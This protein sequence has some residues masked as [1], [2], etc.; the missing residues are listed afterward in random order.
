V[1]GQPGHPGSSAV[2]RTAKSPP[3][4]PVCKVLVSVLLPPHPTS[5]VQKGKEG[6]PGASQ[7][8]RSDAQ[9]RRTTRHETLQMDCFPVHLTDDTRRDEPAAWLHGRLARQVTASMTASP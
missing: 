3:G 1:Q 5:V 8:E 2:I 9:S 4:R 6:R 7:G